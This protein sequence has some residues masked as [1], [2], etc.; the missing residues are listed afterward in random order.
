M[1]SELEQR[2]RLAE[3]ASRAAAGRG[4]RRVSAE[5]RLE[6]ALLSDD[7]P[8]SA[9]RLLEKYRRGLMTLTFA[10]WKLLIGSLASRHVRRKLVRQFMLCVPLSHENSSMQLRQRDKAER[11]LSSKL[12]RLGWEGFA[13]SLR[14]SRAIDKQIPMAL[15]HFRSSFMG[16]VGRTVFSAVLRYSDVRRLKKSLRSLGERNYNA[17]LSYNGLR[18]LQNNLYR[19]RDAKRGQLVGR[20]H[21]FRRLLCTGWM[22][23]TYFTKLCA[24]QRRLVTVAQ[25]HDGWRS[26]LLSFEVLKW[27]A[28]KFA[29]QRKSASD[30]DAF[31]RISRYRYALQC[32]ARNV[33][34]LEYR[35]Q[36][37]RGVYRR[38]LQHKAIIG[39]QLNHYM[40][41]QCA[42]PV[43]DL[44]GPLRYAS[45]TKI[46]SIIRG[47]NARRWIRRYRV[48]RIIAALAIQKAVR[49][50]LAKSKRIA[51]QR[52]R[53]IEDRRRIAAE[54]DRMWSEDLRVRYFLYH[55]A[56][57]LRIQNVFRGYL[58][59]EIMRSRRVC[60]A[61]E[62]A[63]AS[64]DDIK[65]HLEVRQRYIVEEPRRVRIRREA[66]V[67]IQ[68][69]WR[70]VLGKQIAVSRRREL[71]IGAC[72]G[73]LQ[74]ACRV[75]LARRHLEG[76]RRAHANGDRIRAAARFKGSLLRM[77]GFPT[78]R[79]Q[80]KALRVLD[81]LGLHPNSFDYD[82]QNLIRD[83]SV[84]GFKALHA[85][86]RYLRY[87]VLCARYR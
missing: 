27:H 3:K 74:R 34:Y 48:N 42:A 16:R 22:S 46:Q 1:A 35:L 72:I 32:F 20:N 61:K 49:R 78:K 76:L 14:E 56:A 65:Q 5:A 47:F 52:H 11:L 63:I 59:R 80:A 6:E 26:L 21:H 13:N 29:L 2:A 7:L 51:V 58:A 83:T 81:A 54:L 4:K 84:E 25:L 82:L 86:A 31:L 19:E 23:C 64:Y 10:Y 28:L 43:V 12:W 38:K 45:A 70:G 37:M 50:M 75:R 68:K 53:R 15:A 44:I 66:A 69:H 87:L 24:H 9:V 55:E 73:T 18:V 85:T 41:K 17:R 8:P 33:D 62:K 71:K 39:L 79:R 67:L 30:A 77:L 40:V 36:R 60:V 57:V